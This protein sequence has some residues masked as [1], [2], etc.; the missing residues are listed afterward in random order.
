MP[1]Q[2]TAARAPAEQERQKD[3]E[4]KAENA[5]K[6]HGY[7]GESEYK[8][9]RAKAQQ[10]CPAAEDLRDPAEDEEKNPAEYKKRKG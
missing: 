6:G 1:A 4:N 2:P 8:P 9:D 7:K 5:Q 3:A 10:T